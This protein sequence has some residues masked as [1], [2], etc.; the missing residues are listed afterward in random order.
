MNTTDILPI[1][2]LQFDDKGELIITASETSSKHDFDF[3]IGK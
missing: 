2:Q 1:P 3:Y